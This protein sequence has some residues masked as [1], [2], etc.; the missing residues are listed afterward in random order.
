MTALNGTNVAAKVVPFTT[1]DTYATHVSEYGKG[2]WHEVAST[3]DRNAIPADRRTAGMAVYVTNESKL[4]T[5]NEDLTTWTEFESGGGVSDVRVNNVSV[6]ENKIANITIEKPDW[7][8]T[9]STKLNYILHKPTNVSDFT[10]DANYQNASQ[11]GASITTAIGEHNTASDAHSN[12][13]TPIKADIT[14]I[15][16]LIPSAA[17]SSNQLADK[18]FVN[19]SIATSTA[20]FRGTY[21]TLPE[22]EAQT[23]DKEDYGFVI[24]TDTAGNTLYNRYKYNGTSWLYEYTLNNSS[25]TAAQW[26]AINSGVSQSMVDN[27]LSPTSSAATAYTNRISAVESGKVDKTSTANRVYGTNASGAQT[28]WQA[29]TNLELGTDGK[30]NV[31]GVQQQ[32]FEMPEATADLL[33]SIVQYLGDT[34]EDYTHGVM[35]QCVPVYGSFTVTTVGI[36]NVTLDEEAFKNTFLYDASISSY[37]FECTRGGLRQTW[38]LPNGQSWTGN[39]M[40]FGIE[41][42]GRPTDGATITLSRS[43]VGYTWEAYAGVT[44]GNDKIKVVGEKIYGINVLGQYNATTMPMPS[45]ELAGKIIQFNGQASLLS[46]YQDGHFYRC[47]EDRRM[48]DYTLEADPMKY[49]TLVVDDWTALE[50]FMTT[51]DNPVTFIWQGDGRGWVEEDSMSMLGSEDLTQYGIT[52][53]LESGQTLEAGDKITIDFT[54]SYSWN[55][56]S[57]QDGIE[58]VSYLPE[59][60]LEYVDKVL[61]YNNSWDSSLP[62]PESLYVNGKLYTCV[63][64]YN[65]MTGDWDYEW[66]AL[67]Y[68]FS[69]LQYTELPSDPTKVYTDQCVQYVGASQIWEKYAEDVY[70]ENGHIY[71]ATIVDEDDPDFAAVRYVDAHPYQMVYMPDPIAAYEGIIT[72]YVGEDSDYIKGHFYRCVKTGNMTGPSDKYKKP[73]DATWS[74]YIDPD[75]LATQT[76]DPDQTQVFEFQSQAEGADWVL[77]VD[78]Y[79]WTT[80]S[81]ADYGITVIGTVPYGSELKVKY[82]E[83]QPEYEWWDIRVGDY[84]EQFQY[85]PEGELEYM[86][87]T[88]QFVGNE[89]EGYTPNYFYQ[90]MPTFEPTTEGS[91]TMTMTNEEKFAETMKIISP[92]AVAFS[93]SFHQDGGA[94]NYWWVLD[95]L[96][97]D[98]NFIGG[99][100]FEADPTTFEEETGIKIEGTVDNNT[101][102]TTDLS[103][104]WKQVDV[105]STNSIQV[106][107]IPEFTP[108]NVNK[109]VQYVGETNSDYTNGYFYKE[110][111]EIEQTSG[112]A[113]VSVQDAQKFA[114]KISQVLSDTPV[115]GIRINAADYLAPVWELFYLDENGNEIAHTSTPAD[116]AVFAEVTGLL[117]EGTFETGSQIESTVDSGWERIDVQPSSGGGT[118]YT[119]GDGID[120]T[121]DVISVDDIDCGTM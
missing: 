103:V 79:T 105:G 117:V 89:E 60:S 86:G 91:V 62:E 7:T 35:Y 30:I 58:V 20:T 100:S 24:T 5:L 67:P 94:G 54:S 68:Q 21:N 53:T 63:E 120:I 102:I 44:A 118:T 27:Y 90:C 99:N 104:E 114:E 61:L 110:Y 36:S 121:N 19:S 47:E 78:D 38:L 84:I 40:P 3:T 88:V 18:N 97:A 77:K 93:V 16:A 26:A 51:Y 33:G 75:I 2:G 1:E 115:M 66:Q 83:P 34:D 87:R 13:L 92:D 95:A 106:K 43:V 12:I 6:V 14:D 76:A 23:A 119:A 8:E 17:T 116:P 59:P 11:V 111:I 48:R 113:T 72:Q 50:D 41:Y 101:E 29:G 57:V 107:E 112:T 65:E 55:H 37:T 49:S 81:L 28:T 108:E 22:L 98:G 15:Q 74:V 32:M 45:A 96:D 46:M 85:M 64:T 9:D 82:V 42:I 25:F 52:Y 69:L 39:L 73:E 70:L 4:Y 109:I 31:V 56:I 71:R 10:N 80:V